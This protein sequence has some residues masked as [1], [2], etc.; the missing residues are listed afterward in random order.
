MITRLWFPPKG[1]GPDRGVTE[2]LNL[3][4]VIQDQAEK[5]SHFPE[6]ASQLVRSISYNWKIWNDSVRRLLEPHKKNR[7]IPIS[8][9]KVFLIP[10]VSCKN[11]NSETSGESFLSLLRSGI[12]LPP[13]Q[14]WVKEA[15]KVGNTERRAPPAACSSGFETV[16]TLWNT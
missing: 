1:G 10:K 15:G 4:H 11:S 7:Q 2:V 13:P 9:P 16:W 5:K 6:K 12:R 3:S 8:P 14:T